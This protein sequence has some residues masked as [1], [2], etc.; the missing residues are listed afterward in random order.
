MGKSHN[1]ATK[2]K[3]KMAGGVRLP[4]SLQT[5]AYDQASSLLIAVLILL[6]F[7]VGIMVLIWFSSRFKFQRAVVPIVVVEDLGGGGRGNGVPGSEQ[8]LD[9]VMPEEVQDLQEVPPEN[10]LSAVSAAVSAQI[11]NMDAISGSTGLGKGEGTG[12]GDGR[13]PGPGGPGTATELPDWEV[14]F[15]AT[16]LDIYAG[17]L[18][19]FGI[20]LGAIGGGRTQVDYASK[21]VQTRPVSR[22]AEG[23]LEK[24]RYLLWR[25]GPLAAADRELL[26]KAG[27]DSEGRVV[28]QFLPPPTELMMKQLEATHA[29]GRKLS[30]I[31]RT[32]FGVRG[33]PGKYEFYVI[34]QDYRS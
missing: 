18:D 21:L 5:S 2:P 31:R 27:I 8:S 17:Q 10:A 1:S 16:T 6:G 32:V 4:A 13:G 11:P 19:F 34:E 9:E 14:R 7:I 26:K 23:S 20:E 28:L 12:I 24:R 33:T 30:E 15:S 25:K 22:S 29:K 3:P